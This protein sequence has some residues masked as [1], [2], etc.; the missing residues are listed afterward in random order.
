MIAIIHSYTPIAQFFSID[1]LSSKSKNHSGLTELNPSVKIFYYNCVYEHSAL[2]KRDFQPSSKSAALERWKL[3]VGL[4]FLHIHC[5]DW[6]IVEPVLS[7][8]HLLPAISQQ[9]TQILRI[10]RFLR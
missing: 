4:A 1:N 8:S 2:S 7:F 3:S 5:F 10:L 6:L 9:A